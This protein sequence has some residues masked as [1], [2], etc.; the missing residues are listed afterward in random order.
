M[1]DYP[2]HVVTQLKLSPQER[3]L[4]SWFHILQDQSYLVPPAFH[5]LHI[6]SSNGFFIPAVSRGMVAIY[7]S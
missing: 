3:M 2:W 4:I 5:S 7:T 1:Y 6:Y